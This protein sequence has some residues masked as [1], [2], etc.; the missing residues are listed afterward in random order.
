MID[1]KAAARLPRGLKFTRNGLS[2]D[3]RRIEI[4]V[5]DVRDRAVHLADEDYAHDLAPLPIRV[6]N[7]RHRVYAFQWEHAGEAISVCAV[8]SFRRQLFAVARPL[9]IDNPARPDLTEGIAVDSGKVHI[10]AATSLTIP[11][12]LGDGYYPV[13]A[14]LNFGLVV[15]AIVIDFEIWTVRHVILQDHQELDEFGMIRSCD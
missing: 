4:G 5:V 1:V 7:G 2:A 10:E 9:L 14:I 11:S 12:G 8:I 15:Q 6:P 13:F 3:A